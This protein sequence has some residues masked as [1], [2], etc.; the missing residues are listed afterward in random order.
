MDGITVHRIP[1]GL[2]GLQREV[3]SPS[4]LIPPDQGLAP[5]DPLGGSASATPPKSLRAPWNHDG[6]VPA[7]RPRPRAIAPFGYH[8]SGPPSPDTLTG[9]PRLLRPPGRRFNSRSP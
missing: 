9:G 1:D 3:A 6:G 5:V 2:L 7:P 4:R 8:S